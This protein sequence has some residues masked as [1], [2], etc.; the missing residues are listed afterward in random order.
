MSRAWT[1]KGS[2]KRRHNKLSKVLLAGGK[3][4][5]A[6]RKKRTDKN[7][8]KNWPGESQ[9]RGEKD[10]VKGIPH[11]KAGSCRA[12]KTPK[13][14]EARK[15]AKQVANRLIQSLVKPIRSGKKGSWG[16]LERIARRCF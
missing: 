6:E 3:S 10:V 16:R 8:K 14:G 13:I 12:L 2:K 4:S 9:R 7:E 11:L 5:A 1:H 15:K